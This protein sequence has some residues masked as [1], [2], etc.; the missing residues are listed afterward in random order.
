MLLITQFAEVFWLQ[1]LA[2][3]AQR[4]QL[5]GGGGADPWSVGGDAEEWR[6]GMQRLSLQGGGSEPQECVEGI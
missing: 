5:Y 1:V 6:A 4:S 2:G 3:I